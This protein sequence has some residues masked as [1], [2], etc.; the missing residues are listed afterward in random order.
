MPGPESTT[1]MVVAVVSCLTRTSMVPPSGVYLMALSSRLS[2]AC[3]NTIRSPNQ[4]GTASHRTRTDWLF[5]SARTL[6]CSATSLASSGISTTSI[7]RF[8]RP[9]SPRDSISRRSTSKASRS[10][11]SSMLPMISRYAFSSRRP[12]KPTSPTLRM[13][14]SG[15]LNS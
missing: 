1:S 2:M 3:R 8:L 12:R 4:R 7:D 9:V 10:T 6:N 14:V 13:A 5:S 15:V 11:S